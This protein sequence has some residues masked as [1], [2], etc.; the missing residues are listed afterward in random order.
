ME[1]VDVVDRGGN[2]LSQISKAEAHAKG[3]LHRCVIAEVKNSKGEW[4]LVKQAAD[5]QD[6]GQFVSPVGGHISAGESVESALA[7][8]TQE[9]L[10]ITAGAH[11]HIGNGIFN[12]ASRGKQENHYFIVYEIIS[13]E[14]PS[15]NHES[16]EYQYFPEEEIQN[17]IQSNPERFGDAFVFIL[18]KFYPH[19]L[20]KD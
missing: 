11:K 15:L 18:Q 7:R 13:D 17:G 6:A 8:E 20:Q 14:P 9:E 5:R 16:I 19:L 4:L 1:Y 3:M 10:G 2:I 12:R